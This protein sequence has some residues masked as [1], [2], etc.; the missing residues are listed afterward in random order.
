[1]VQVL[2]DTVAKP[3]PLEQRSGLLERD[4]EAYQEGNSDRKPGQNAAQSKAPA[5]GG[6]CIC[7]N[8]IFVLQCS[9]ARKFSVAH[10]VFARHR[11]DE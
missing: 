10:P 11:L 7:S 8:A 9:L 6:F 4:I 1:V 5:G 3:A 2:S